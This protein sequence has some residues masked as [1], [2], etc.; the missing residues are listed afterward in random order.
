MSTVRRSLGRKIDG[1]CQLVQAPL[2]RS[3]HAELQNEDLLAGFL[4][5]Q[6]TLAGALGAEIPES[7]DEVDRV[8][9]AAAAAD[10]AAPRGG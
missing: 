1:R 5:K 9:E 4:A 10:P 7:E 3:Q 6:R 8:L 2:F